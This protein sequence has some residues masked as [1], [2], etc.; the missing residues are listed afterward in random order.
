MQPHQ[1]E[2]PKRAPRK[3]VTTACVACRESKIRCDG[4]TPHCQNCQ[5]KGKECKY[6]HG[7]DKR[8]YV[9]LRRSSHFVHITRLGYMS[10]THHIGGR[11]ERWITS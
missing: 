10:C 5:R 1:L 11:R 3:H 6:Q 8:K 4:S 7:D 9:L 2:K